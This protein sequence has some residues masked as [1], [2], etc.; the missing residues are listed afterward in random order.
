MSDGLGASEKGTR[1]GVQAVAAVVVVGAIIGG[2]WGLDKVFPKTRAESEPAVCSPS[3]TP[4][5]TPGKVSSGSAV[6]G[7]QLCEALNRPDLAALLGTPKEHALNADGDESVLTLAGGSKVST[8]E[9]EVQLAT[10]SVKLT[11]SDDELPVSGLMRYLGETAVSRAVLGHAAILYSDRTIAFTF[12]LGGG[13]ADTGPGGIARTLVVAR[14]PK[15][16]GGTFDVA[17]WRQDDVPPDDAAL[18][19]VAEQVL[20]T[21]A[22]WKSH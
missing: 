5:S 12:D 20:P 19:R 8:P 3:G 4:T 14:D 22:G 17:I 9:A 16:G 18:F 10:Y 21:I 2:M 13:K 11:A 1:A 15:D 7:A 6:T